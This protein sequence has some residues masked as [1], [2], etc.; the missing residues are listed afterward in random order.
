MSTMAQGRTLVDEVSVV[1]RVACLVQ[2]IEQGSLSE[3]LPRG[4]NEEVK[5]EIYPEIGQ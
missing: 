4:T 5:E 1:Y 2:G 3:S